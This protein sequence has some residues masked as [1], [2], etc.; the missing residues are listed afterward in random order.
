MAKYSTAV[1]QS[2]DAVLIIQNH[3][4]RFVNRAVRAIYGYEPNEMIGMPAMSTVTPEYMDLINERLRRKAAGLQTA[5]FYEMRIRCKG[6]GTR[7]VEVFTKEVSYE[8]KAATM[9]IVR[10]ITSRREAESKIVQRGKE[11]DALYGGLVSIAQS[12][13]LKKSL[14]QVCHQVNVATGSVFSCI[15]VTDRNGGV[16]LI[17]D[18][19]PVKDTSG[20]SPQPSAV[21]LAIISQA[22]PVVV[23]DCC[24]RTRGRKDCTI[25]SWAGI[26]IG[27]KNAVLGALFVYSSEPKAFSANLGLLSAFANQAAIA[28]KN[29]RLYEA[30]KA[31][32]AR[33]EMLLAKVITA[34]EDERRRV[35]LDLH[36]SVAQSIYGTLARIG[37]AEQLF[38]QSE[39][40]EA[41]AE[42]EYARGA[43]EQT[44][45]D[46][47][48]V[49]VDLHP[50]ALDAVGLCEALRQLSAESS[51]ANPQIA[52]A[53]HMVGSPVRLAAPT[54][55]AVYRIVQE[56]LSNTRKHASATRVWIRI[57]FLAKS[58][59]VVVRDN[60]RGFDFDGAKKRQP[61]N[62]HLGLAGMTERAELIA[63]LLDIETGPGKG[64]TVRLSIPLPSPGVP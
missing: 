20:L 34:Q 13:D 36:D 18:R 48:R 5:L 64:T 60:G 32:Q 40:D 56:A 26:P 53:F 41:K 11:L 58:V 21:M 8:G 28:I 12:F 24:R 39:Y 23:N 30:V 54:E 7:D 6:G 16:I 59:R 61:R 14:R 47:R 49:A 31:E 55:V 45:V 25:R 62:G 4:F 9:A 37:A 22:K 29:G 33:A 44:L 38:S 15:A 50:P 17:G 35:S 10:D 27:V 52:C 43:I 42:I 46:L 51:Q 1:E 19:P 2:V 57:R 3:E 63:G